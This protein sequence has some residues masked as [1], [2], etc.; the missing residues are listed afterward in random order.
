M[1]CLCRWWEHACCRF[2]AALVLSQTFRMMFVLHN[3]RDSKQPWLQ[4][5][6]STNIHADV[7]AEILRRG[8]ALRAPNADPFD[9]SVCCESDCED[10]SESDPMSVSS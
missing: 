4:V 8:H 10:E 1:P 5:L 7:R 2:E 9:G 6:L 3:W